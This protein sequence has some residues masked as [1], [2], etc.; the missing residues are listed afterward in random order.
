MHPKLQS[1][2]IHVGTSHVVCSFIATLSVV[3][4]VL[5]V[6]FCCT[7]C[8]RLEEA[9]RLKWQHVTKRR[10]CSCRL[11][12]ETT[13]LSIAEYQLQCSLPKLAPHLNVLHTNVSIEFNKQISNHKYWIGDASLITQI[14]EH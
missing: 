1:Q 12:F 3:H 5:S 11:V 13:H 14:L 8:E 4:S 9:G 7:G 6:L 2:K 10:D